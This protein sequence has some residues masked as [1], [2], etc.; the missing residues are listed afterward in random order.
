MLTSTLGPPVPITTSTNAKSIATSHQSLGG[1]VLSLPNAIGCAASIESDVGLVKILNLCVED[2][3]V[4]G[5]LF[6][7]LVS[8]S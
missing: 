6:D 4:G 1:F 8:G 7:R 2:A 3:G 5:I